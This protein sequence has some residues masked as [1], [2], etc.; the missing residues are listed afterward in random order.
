MNCPDCGVKPGEKHESGCDVE[1]CPFCGGQLLSCNCCYE[2][3][4]PEFGWEYKPVMVLDFSELEKAPADYAPKHRYRVGRWV[5]G[6]PTNGLPPDV[7]Y[8]GI[9]D[10]MAARWEQM[11]EERGRVPWT[12]E[13]PGVA[14]C[15][16]LGLWC[17]E[18]P[19]GHGN[20]AMNYG[21]ISCDK[22]HPEARED[23]NRL[24]TDCRW[25]PDKKQFVLKST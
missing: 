22:D 1:R 7:Y 3:L 10:E 19:S 4:G 21:W 11:L 24:C 6:H 23:L 14:D 15:Q 5:V 2:K 8:N 9:T 17:Y 18:D 13:W 20:P 25:D 16:R 12:G